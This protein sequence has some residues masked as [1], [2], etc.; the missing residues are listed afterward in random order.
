MC[1]DNSFSM[2][3][4]KTVF[5]E[6]ATATEESDENGGD[7]GDSWE[8]DGGK[9]FYDGLRPDEVYDIQARILTEHYCSKLDIPFSLQR[10]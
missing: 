9:A 5:F 7:G 1:F 2:F 6:L 8:D 4:T 3:N 10:S